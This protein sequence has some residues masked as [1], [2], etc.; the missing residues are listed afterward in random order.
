MRYTGDRREERTMWPSTMG[1]IVTFILSL[2][3]APLAV[4]AQ[5]AGKVYRIGV[6]ERTSMA[7]NAASF[8]AFRHGL[9]EL[10]YVEGQNIVIE[11]RS[12][13]GR[14]ERFPDLAAELVQL[15]V[16]LIVTRGTQAA[17]AAKRATDTLPVVMVGTGNPVVAGIVA[18]LAHPGG[19]VT[20]LTSSSTDLDAK[21]VEL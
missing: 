4:E 7:V 19:N 1:C 3:V 5:Q 17:L 6:L 20:G 11:Y 12:A 10:G 21:R 18:S 8:D 14:D 2:L 16:D 13:D 15:K 9:Q